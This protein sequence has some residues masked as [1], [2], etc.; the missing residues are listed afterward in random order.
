MALSIDILSLNQIRNQRQIPI[1]RSDW[2]VK[3]EMDR[4]VQPVVDLMYINVIYRE[5][6][7][8]QK[9]LMF[10]YPIYN[11]NWRNISTIYIY[12]YNKTKIKGNILTIKKYNGN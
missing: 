11:H 10:V 1:S 7:K 3:C 4:M 5:G 2:G 6:N 12:E 9:R 8:R